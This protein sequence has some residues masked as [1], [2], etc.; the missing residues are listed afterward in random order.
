[1]PSEHT[2]QMGME[3]QG[4]GGERTGRGRGL[5]RRKLGKGHR[6]LPTEVFHRGEVMQPRPAD[7]PGV[8]NNG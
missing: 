2:A 4:E 3:R 5:V 7:Q 1:M 6:A 8:G